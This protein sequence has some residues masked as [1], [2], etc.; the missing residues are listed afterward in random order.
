MWPLRKR[1]YQEQDRLRAAEATVNMIVHSF[2]TSIE[3]LRQAE[4]LAEE[5]YSAQGDVIVEAK[6]RQRR[7]DEQA[8]RASRVAGKLRDLVS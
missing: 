4:L 3:A 1:E 6:E 2:E 8:A 5:E 7:A